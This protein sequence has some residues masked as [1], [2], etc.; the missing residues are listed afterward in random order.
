ME[1]TASWALLHA[2]RVAA[3]AAFAFA[4]LIAVLAF[5]PRASAVTCESPAVAIAGD[6]CQ[7]I[8]STAGSFTW[9]APAGVAKVDVLL[10]GAGG[11][12]GTPGGGGGGEV[13]IV[14]DH[15]VTAGQGYAVV[16]G[17]GGSGAG[18]PTGTGG[19]ASS[20]DG[21]ALT[22]A[23]GAG[24]AESVY[25]A[26]GGGGGAA[27]GASGAAGGT[28][29][30]SLINTAGGAGGGG[31]GA[32]GAGANG[33]SGTGGAGGSGVLVPA[34]DWPGLAVTHFGSGGGG[35]G[36][37]TAGAGGAETGGA[38]ARLAS[39]PANGSAGTYGGGGGGTACGQGGRGGAGVVV[40]R[41]T[42]SA[43]SSPAAATG[44]TTT[45]A[46][47]S[48]TPAASTAT[49]SAKVLS[50]AGNGG[51]RVRITATGAGTA[52]V[53]GVRTGRGTRA[54]ETVCTV[55][56]AFGKSGTVALVCTPSA[57]TRALR[58]QGPVRVALTLSFTPRSG[59]A[60]T[61]RLGT[62]VLPRI[63]TTPSAVTG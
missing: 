15:A 25:T 8:Y 17:A 14:T 50:T 44:A 34:A 46:T 20:F 59:K 47:P 26:S 58:K 63:A 60:T 40:V 32:A 41:Y 45:G 39:C 62:V 48:G 31:G 43:A 7:A 4:M 23:G 9:T 51:I 57:A 36:Y 49:A 12:G 54:A 18:G 37:A 27:G 42:P 33:S 35:G 55:T 3:V 53:T 30:G 10:V 61:S 56:Y 52:R 29:S 13:R 16:V 38:G 19:A 6:R 5:A 11:G 24:G 22:A 28:G 1:T 21:S 2:R